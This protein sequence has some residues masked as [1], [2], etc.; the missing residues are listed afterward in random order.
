MSYDPQTGLSDQGLRYNAHDLETLN[1]AR[2]MD[3]KAFMASDQMAKDLRSLKKMATN[4]CSNPVVLGTPELLQQRIK[5][6]EEE[7]KKN[8]TPETSENPAPFI[9]PQQTFVTPYVQPA[10]IRDPD[11]FGGERDQYRT[12]RSH[13]LLK[14]QGDAA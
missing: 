11:P 10:P 5:H 2:N 8:S 14:V 9:H 7:L 4:L 12:F 13:L 6:L 3:V 1:A